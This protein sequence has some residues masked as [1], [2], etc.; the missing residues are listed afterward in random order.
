MPTLLIIRAIHNITRTRIA[1]FIAAMCII[2][3]I[4]V[5]LKMYSYFGSLN[6]GVVFIPIY[7]ILAVYH[8]GFYLCLNWFA[9]AT[10]IVT[11]TMTLNRD[12]GRKMEDG[13][14]CLLI[15]ESIILVA[16]L[17][18]F[19]VSIPP[20]GRGVTE[21]DGIDNCFPSL[22]SFLE[23]IFVLLFSRKVLTNKI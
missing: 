14:I 22:T 23:C 10:I 12:R 6:W 19:C 11:F 15:M 2:E 3:V 20:H 4:L 17:G 8:I 5:M 13:L 18:Y 7:L 1:I 16:E 9:L 21:Q